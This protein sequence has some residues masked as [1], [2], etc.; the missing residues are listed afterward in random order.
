MTKVVLGQLTIHMKK[1]KLDPYFHFFSFQQMSSAEL[2]ARKSTCPS[3]NCMIGTWSGVEE[4]QEILQGEQEGNSALRRASDDSEKRQ[5][6]IVPG[7]E[8]PRA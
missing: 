8:D 4:L 5:L 1:D 2:R 7:A 6:S 3:I